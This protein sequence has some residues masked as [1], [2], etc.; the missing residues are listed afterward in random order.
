MHSR[1][2]SSHA[3]E[4][5]L[6]DAIKAISACIRD[7]LKAIKAISAC[8]RDALK[9]IKAISAC[10]RDAPDGG[11]TNGTLFQEGTQGNQGNQGN[12]CMHSRCTGRWR[13]EWYALPRGQS[14]R[15]GR[16]GREKR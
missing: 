10:I 16:R 2:L 6:W 8:I 12:Q 5:H 14:R 4:M 3:F 13:Y 11:V 7:A 1:A 9:A 15:S